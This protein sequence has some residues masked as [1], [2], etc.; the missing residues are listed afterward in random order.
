MTLNVVEKR[1]V[2]LVR[3]VQ[4]ASARR[5]R[6]RPRVVRRLPMTLDRQMSGVS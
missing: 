6:W 2:V 5:A 1:P 4:S 3:F